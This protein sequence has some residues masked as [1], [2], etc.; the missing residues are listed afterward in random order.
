VGVFF[1]VANRDATRYSFNCLQTA[2][3]P[4]TLDF[5]VL[6]LDA[7]SGNHSS[8]FDIKR[9]RKTGEKRLFYGVFECG[10]H[11]IRTQFPFQKVLI[12]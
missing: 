12:L 8:V 1:Y 4:K 6:H 2:I 10:G 5:I 11:G 9:P 7:Q 3:K